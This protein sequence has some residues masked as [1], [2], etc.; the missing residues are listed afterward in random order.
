[1][2]T[3]G[4]TPG[5]CSYVLHQD[6]GTKWVLAGDAAKNRGELSTGEVQITMDPAM[7]TASLELIRKTADR[8]LPGHD[9]WVT[10]R[11][12]KIIA[13]GG[14]DKVLVFAQGITINGGETRVVLH[15]D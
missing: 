3:P 12:G 10:I 8:V 2:L 9:G 1:M 5:S 4:H 15:M 7:S 14:N 11:D 13:E 6:D